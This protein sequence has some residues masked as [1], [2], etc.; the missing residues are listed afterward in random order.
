MRPIRAMRR[1]R[2]TRGSELCAGPGTPQQYPPDHGYAADLGFAED[3]GYAGDLGFVRDA[4]LVPLMEP[5]PDP[6]ELRRP[7]AGAGTVPTRRPG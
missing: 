2:A 3:P 4:G 1:I 6:Q 7:G 5:L